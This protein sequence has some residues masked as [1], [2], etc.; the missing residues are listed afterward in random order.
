[1]LLFRAWWR[2]GEKE[3]RGVEVV[4]S[5]IFLV[6]PPWN[7]MQ[8]FWELSAADVWGRWGFG[9]AEGLAGSHCPVLHGNVVW[10][11]R[12]LAGAEG[13]VAPP[14]W[15]LCLKLPEENSCCT[16]LLLSWEMLTWNPLAVVV[17]LVR[18]SLLWLLGD[19]GVGVGWAGGERPLPSF[20]GS[21]WN[22][23]GI[24]ISSRC[25]TVQSQVTE[26]TSQKRLQSSSGVFQGF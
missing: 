26:R 10:A 14:D 11:C 25:L 2:R 16:V 21:G 1:M 15:L 13:A 5:C 3:R 8:W 9:C 17:Q 20:L 24:P 6:S 22:I 19:L 23:C 7:Q 18:R 4:S 12:P